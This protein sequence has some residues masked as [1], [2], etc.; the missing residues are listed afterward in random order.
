V[1]AG[2]RERDLPARN[3]A[4][5]LAREWGVQN[6]ILIVAISILA[7]ISYGDVRTR[8]IPNALSLAIAS[9]GLLRII[10]AHDHV[11]AGN[12][13]TAGTVVLA[14]AWL[15]FWGG[16]IGGGD[17]KLI[18]AMTLLVGYQDLLRFLVL[19]SIF[20]GALALAIIARNQ[21]RARL[22]RSRGMPLTTEPIRCGAPPMDAT[23]PYGVAIAAAGAI[24]L[25]CNAVVAR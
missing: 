9:L 16:V 22:H 15:L 18:A 19:M 4:S 5:I 10:L 6:S 3:P 14:V 13:L 11:A 24:M 2:R 21:L 23:V 20:G 17:A 25:V 1:N 8:R 12:T 7:A